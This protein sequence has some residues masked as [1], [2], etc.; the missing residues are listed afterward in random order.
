MN[1]PLTPPLCR[2]AGRGGSAPGSGAAS[3]S[4]P[5]D[6]P[7]HGRDDGLRLIDVWR[8][9]AIRQPEQ[10]DVGGRFGD[11]LDLSHRRVFIVFTLHRQQRTT[12][13]RQA[14]GNLPARE[15]GSQPGVVPGSK[16]DIRVP[17]VT[18]ELHSPIAA[19]IGFACA[20]DA[21]ESLLLDKLVRGP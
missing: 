15:F 4:Q 9:P 5:L 7:H 14:V 6:K 2:R 12:D 16:N 3:D 19:R 20:A 17:V 1:Q 18:S 10:F 11:A 13:R 21:I 8:M